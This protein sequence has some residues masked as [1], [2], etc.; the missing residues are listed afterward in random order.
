MIPH[1]IGSQNAPK[2]RIVNRTQ[3]DF[4]WCSRLYKDE[5]PAF[6]AA[7][8]R[9]LAR[10]DSFFFMAGLMGFRATDF[11]AGAAAFFAGDFPLRCAH[12]SFIVAEMR[13]RAAGDIVRVRCADLGGRPRRGVDPSRAVIA[14]SSRLTSCL[15]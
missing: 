7:A 15:R 13:F 6:F 11:L 9:A 14:A 10:A 5:A 12:L 1:R 2:L 8:Q 4:V 3:N